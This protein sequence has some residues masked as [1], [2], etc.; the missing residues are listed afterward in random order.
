[1]DGA[2]VAGEDRHIFALDEQ[3]DECARRRVDFFDPKDGRRVRLEKFAS[4][5]RQ[6]EV[7][8]GNGRPQRVE[9]LLAT[10]L[11]IDRKSVVKGQSVAGRVDLG[12]GRTVNKKTQQK[13]NKISNKTTEQN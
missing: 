6:P 2:S 8:H 11:D 12:V 9:P 13:L 4:R 1:M 10:R 7:S 5:D 3:S